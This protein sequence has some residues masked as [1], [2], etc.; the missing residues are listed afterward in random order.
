MDNLISFYLFIASI[1]FFQEWKDT[2]DFLSSF[3]IG[4]FWI[5]EVF[6]RISNR[7]Q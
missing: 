5:Y 2:K 3:I 1:W 4:L 7:F 6:H